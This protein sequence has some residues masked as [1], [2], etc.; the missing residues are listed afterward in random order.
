[1]ESKI[2][3]IWL[4]R[5]GNQIAIRNYWEWI[6]VQKLFFDFLTWSSLHVIQPSKQSREILLS[7]TLSRENKCQIN[8]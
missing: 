8:H 2:I 5:N 4:G 3:L 6:N 1:M 7:E